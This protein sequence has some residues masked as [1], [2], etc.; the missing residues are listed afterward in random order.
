MIFTAYSGDHSR[1]RMVLGPSFDLP[2]MTV[3]IPTMQDR[4]N[5]TD[6]FCIF[7]WGK[8]RLKIK[9]YIDGLRIMSCSGKTF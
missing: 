6:F 8:L 7:L 5:T 2:T 4:K 9:V 3:T 1:V